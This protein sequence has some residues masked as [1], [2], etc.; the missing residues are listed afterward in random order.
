MVSAPSLSDLLSSYSWDRSKSLTEPMPSQRGHM[1]PRRWNVALT[2][3]FAPRSTVIAPLARTDGTLKEKAFGEPICGCPRR[4]NRMRSIALASVAVPTVERTSAPIRSWSTMIAVV[5]PSSTSTSGRASV[6]M[7]PC[8][9]ALY[10][11]LIIR[12]DSAAIVPNT[13]ELLPEPETPVNAVSRRFGISTL[14]SLRLFTRAPCTRI[15]S[16]LSARCSAGACVSVLVAMLIVSPSVGRGRIRVPV[17]VPWRDPASVEQYVVVFFFVRSA[18]LLDADHVARGIAEGAV[19]NAV[20]LLGGL[21][22][23]LGIPGLQ[24]LEGA[25]EVLGGQEDPAVG[26]LRHHLRDGAA[27]VVGDARVD[28][29]RRQEDGRVGLVGRADRDPSH[30]AL[31][32]VGADLEAEGVAVEGQGGV[33]VVVGKDGRVNGEVHGGHARDG[34]VTWASR[35][36]TGL[37]TCFATQDGMPAVPCAAR[38]R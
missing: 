26:A 24:P 34:S 15:R 2:A 16:W 4:L 13:S 23:D 29:R 36:L 38:R 31:S 18:Q 10:V 37:V 1:P 35:F 27:F 30:R 19:A 14:T 3:F 21:L 25:V 6:G 9:K 7:K 20:R 8:T 11:S 28:A 12:C 5:S 33:R 17:G 32:D 22:D